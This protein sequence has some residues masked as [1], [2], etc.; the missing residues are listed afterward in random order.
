MKVKKTFVYCH[1]IEAFITFIC[2][3]RGYEDGDVEVDIGLDSGGGFCK[4]CMSV[5][6]VKPEET[7]LELGNGEIC[8]PPPKKRKQSGFLATGVKGCFVI[9][10]VQDIPES[11]KNIRMMVKEELGIESLSWFNVCL[12]IKAKNES[13]GMQ[14]ASSTHSCCYCY[15]KAPFDNLAEMILRTFGSIKKDAKGFLDLVRKIG[16]K[17]ALKK[18]KDFFNQKDYPIFCG[19]DWETILERV[20]LSECHLI[21]GIVNKIFDDLYKS[22]MYDI[23]NDNCHKSVYKWANEKHIAPLKYFGG[24]LDGP[25]CERL[26]NS[27]DCAKN[28]LSSIVPEKFQPFVNCLRIF[29]KVKHACFGTVLQTDWNVHIDEFEK[30]YR[31]L[32]IIDKTGTTKKISV[33]PKGSFHKS[34]L[35]FLAFFDLV[36]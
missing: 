36:K 7:E 25:N 14:P 17:R 28:S 2:D 11:Y 15:G 3:K 35:R 31:P 12:D 34:C 16:Y 33:T 18:A 26:L 4:I 22:M 19:K 8:M 21:L 20:D 5:N 13:L 32:D 24:A 9:G 29:A 27:I 23:N 30:A 10:I 6:Q 1:C